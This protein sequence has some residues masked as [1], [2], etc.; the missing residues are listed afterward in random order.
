MITPQIAES[1]LTSV[2]GAMAAAK[3]H[4]R[5]HGFE[6]DLLMDL[7]AQYN[8]FWMPGIRETLG[9]DYVDAELRKYVA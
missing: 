9:D 4:K 2:M 7:I 8:E 1:R 3:D 6:D 5:I